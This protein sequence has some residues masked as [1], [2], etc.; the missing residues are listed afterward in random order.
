MVLLP[1]LLLLHDPFQSL[2]WMSLTTNRHP[3]V[4]CLDYLRGNVDQCRGW[5][6]VLFRYYV[7][8]QPSIIFLEQGPGWDMHQLKHHRRPGIPL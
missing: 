4:A 2:D 8:M 7:P 5:S 6:H 1:F 3:E